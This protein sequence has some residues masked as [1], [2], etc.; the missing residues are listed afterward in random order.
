MSACGYFQIKR[1]G[2]KLNEVVD[3]SLRVEFSKL[4]N[5]QPPLW[6]Y[7]D[8]EYDLKKGECITGMTEFTVRVNDK[9]MKIYTKPFSVMMRPD[10]GSDKAFQIYS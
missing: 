9:L 3:S 4:P 6:F 1:F 10:Y 7:R 5:V 8:I 2:K